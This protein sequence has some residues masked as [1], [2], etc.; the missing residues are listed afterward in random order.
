MQSLR[1]IEFR[2][3]SF[4][5]CAFIG[6]IPIKANLSERTY[7]LLAKTGHSQDYEQEV[8]A[9][10]NPSLSHRVRDISIEVVG[11]AVCRSSVKPQAKNLAH[12]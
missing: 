1:Y 10:V 8:Q 5:N 3:H 6:I 7:H 12:P 2:F 4:E 9:K 11:C